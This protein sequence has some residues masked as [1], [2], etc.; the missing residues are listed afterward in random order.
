MES[1]MGHIRDLPQPSAAHG[2]EEGPNT[3]KFAVDVS[4]SSRPYYVVNRTK[5]KKVTELKRKL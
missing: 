2:H 5:K 3:G 1:S 4:T